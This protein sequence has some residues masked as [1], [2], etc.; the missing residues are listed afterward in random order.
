MTLETSVP[1][2]TYASAS[3]LEQ[4]DSRICLTTA[5][6]QPPT[7]VNSRLLGAGFSVR[8]ALSFGADNK[9]EPQ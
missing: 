1:L 4:G 8:L 9:R 2:R 5:K 6:C 7:G 3:V